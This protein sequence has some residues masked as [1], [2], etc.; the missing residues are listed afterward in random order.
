M[1]DD[2]RSA[3]RH[4]IQAETLLEEVLHPMGGVECKDMY[5]TNP[6][7]GTQCLVRFAQYPYS[8]T[9]MFYLL[10]YRTRTKKQVHIYDHVQCTCASIYNALTYMMLYTTVLSYTSTASRI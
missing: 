1:L 3:D 8:A 9:R 5:H 2:P 4:R 10:L 7:V 6:H